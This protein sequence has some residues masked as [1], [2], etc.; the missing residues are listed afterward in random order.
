MGSTDSLPAGLPV[1]NPTTPFWRTELH[2]LDDLRATPELPQQSDIVIIG[3]GYAGVSIAYHLLK[4]QDQKGQPHPSITIL[5]ARQI[6]S[7]ATGRNGGHIRPDLYG[8]IPT[9]IERH[10][11]EAGVELA[12]FEL[13]H[14]KALKDVIVKEEIDCDLNITRNMNVYLNEA[15][16][17]KAKRTYEALASQAHSF[18]E[19]IHYTPQKHA[20]G[21][22]GVKGAK[23][24]MSYTAGTLWPYKFVL[25]LLSKIVDYSALN[26][27][28][29]TPVTSVS[30]ES[31][32]SHLVNT[33][34]GS[35]HA[36][37]VIYATN[38][39]TPGLL[40]EYSSHIV[41]V[42]GI[43]C[44]ITIPEGKNA[45]FLPYS[46]IL[47]TENGDGCSYLITRPD[48]S[49][50]TGGAQYTFKEAKEQ[51]Y[52]VVDDSTLIEPAKDY[53]NDYMQR[54]FQGWE[55]SGAYVK[56]I[57]TGIMG[58][59]YDS[60]PHVGEIPDKPGQ[61]ICAGFNGHGMPVIFLTAKGLAEIIQTGKSF[62]EAKLPRIF[63]ST[64][65]RLQAA[66]EASDGGDVLA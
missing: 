32:S 29:N 50:I 66:Q 59:S 55:D 62:E 38:A 1:G 8:H 22:S 57:W 14:V 46:Y 39:Y 63:K 3:A 21:I 58:Y 36:S 9:Y 49:I 60:N 54:T 11:T 43:C 17:E 30:S 47:N 26:V 15:H 10:G 48:G 31:D 7:G 25:G 28:A 51:W 20:E 2:P 24:C 64:M 23:A 44:H 37:K 33:P 42:R 6:C 65:K 16:G 13:S 4:Q 40:P 18:V 12:N 34:R 56:E 27:Q 45:P 19:D 41:P 61:Y 52:G 5:E 53:Y 35:I